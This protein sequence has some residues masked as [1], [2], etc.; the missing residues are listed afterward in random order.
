MA[1]QSKLSG[2]QVASSACDG[3]RFALPSAAKPLMSRLSPVHSSSASHPKSSELPRRA[4]QLQSRAA[5]RS[6]VVKAA[7]SDKP[8]KTKD[9]RLV[10][11]DGSVWHGVSF[12]AKGTEIGEVVFNTS[13]S[14]YQEIM[15]DP[16]YKGQ[17]VAFTCPHIGNVGINTG[18]FSRW[19]EFLCRLAKSAQ[20]SRCLIQFTIFTCC[21]GHGVF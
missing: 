13:L 5:R 14:G 19:T 7:A 4:A 1:L 3:V 21:R 6:V 12:G 15:T 20:T 2:R 17:F 8:W 11:E 10:L 18:V 16:S 9:A